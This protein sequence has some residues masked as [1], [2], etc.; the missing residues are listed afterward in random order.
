MHIN[1]GNALLRGNPQGTH[2][3]R[4]GNAVTGLNSA[5]LLLLMIVRNNDFNIFNEKIKRLLCIVD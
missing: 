2:T 3:E 5:E 1:K 4:K